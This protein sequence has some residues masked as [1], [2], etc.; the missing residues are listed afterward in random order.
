MKILGIS[1]G[2]IAEELGIKAGDELVSINGHKIRDQLDYKFYQNEEYLEVLIKQSG[3]EIIFEIE[4]EA[5]EDLGLELEP[6]ELR[7]CGNK[8][9]FCFVYQNPKGLRKTLYIKDEDYRFS[10]LYGH[11]VT[12]TNAKE[13]DLHRIVEQRMTPLYISVHATDPELRKLLLGI[14]FEDHLMNKLKFLTENGIEIHA[15]IVL[16]P[17]LN[18]G[19][20]LVKTVTDLA[21]LYPGIRSV[22]I[23]PVGLTRHRKNLFPIQAVTD[24]YA[25]EIIDFTDRLRLLMLKKIGDPFVY[26]SDEFF[27]R[28]GLEI[29]G[30]DYYGEFHQLENGVG[31]TRNLIQILHNE[32]GKIKKLPVKHKKFTFVSGILG[33]AALKKYILPELVSMGYKI[34]LIPVPNKF[35]G[36]SIT[37]SGL[38]VGQD[39]YNTLKNNTVSDYIVLPPRCL[40]EDNL[41]L[42]DWSLE[43][44][45]KRLDKKCIPFPESF[46]ELMEKVEEYENASDRYSG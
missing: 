26:L 28:T 37:V 6:L 45:E 4:K 30:E 8:C 3:E 18:D 9:I 21:Q 25:R 44:L 19:D 1:E 14:K 7:I 38:L 20:Q 17:G 24:D 5:H 22:A 36:E 39:I 13:E 46:V 16:C 32:K 2:S 41:F 15:Q 40:N 12:L 11:Y 35:Y 27:I 29:P 31:L 23:V 43:D 33:A 10:F 42:D 34:N